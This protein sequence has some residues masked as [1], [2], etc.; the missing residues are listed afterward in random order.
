[1][2]PRL[3]HQVG[4]KLNMI[5]SGA[6]SW[7][8]S[9]FFIGRVQVM[10]R[11]LGHAPA[12]SHTPHRVPGL[13]VSLLLVCSALIKCS[14]SGRKIKCTWHIPSIL[15][16]CLSHNYCHVMC[17]TTVFDIATLTTFSFIEK[18]INRKSGGGGEDSN[19]NDR[20]LWMR[21]QNISIVNFPYN[22]ANIL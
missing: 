17:I 2:E 14:Q 21:K 1:M 16:L 18:S 3:Q 15:T 9:Q 4:E 11:T 12:N 7:P 5:G 8:E 6:V 20:L 10:H 22:C 19:Q 13:L